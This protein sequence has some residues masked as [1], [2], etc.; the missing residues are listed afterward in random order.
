MNILNN[1][2][3]ENDWKYSN[4]NLRNDQDSN[5]GSNYDIENSMKMAKINN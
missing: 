5:D 1:L 3:G 4:F 2:N